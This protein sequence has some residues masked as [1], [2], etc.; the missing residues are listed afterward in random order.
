MQFVALFAGIFV[1]AASAFDWDWFFTNRKAIFFT[2][3]LGRG[4]VRIFYCFLG[5]ILLALSYVMHSVGPAAT[6]VGS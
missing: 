6:N 5:L 4:G 2:N 3:L 1:I